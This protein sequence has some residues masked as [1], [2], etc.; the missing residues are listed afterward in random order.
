MMERRFDV[1][2]VR[3]ESLIW[4]VQK[5]KVHVGKCLSYSVYCKGFNDGFV[6]LQFSGIRGVVVICVLPVLVY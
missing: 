4:L 2:P 6:I 5:E 3:S 1:C